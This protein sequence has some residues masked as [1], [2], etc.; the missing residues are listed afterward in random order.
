M[1]S[2][3]D[4]VAA[5][6]QG[7][8]RVEGTF[9]ALDEAR[10]DTRVHDGEGGWTARQVLAHLAGRAHGHD[11]LLRMAEAGDAPDFGAIDVNHWNQELVDARAAATRDE[12]LAEFRAVHERLIERVEALPDEVLERQLTMPSGT[13]SAGDALAGSGGM[14]SIRHTEEVEHALGIS[15]PGG[16]Q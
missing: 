4:I 8:A 3:A 9:G 6:Q 13:F 15:A 12:L 11:V 16:E 5:I 10:L 2:K 1:A 14:H 7:I